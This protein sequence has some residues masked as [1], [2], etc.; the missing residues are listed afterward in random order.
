M[1]F[2]QSQVHTD[3]TTRLLANVDALSGVFSFL[4]VNTAACFACEDFFSAWYHITGTLDT[5]R[6]YDRF[7][8]MFRVWYDSEMKWFYKKKFPTIERGK[9]CDLLFNKFLTSHALANALRSTLRYI[10]VQ[11]Q[12]GET[13]RREFRYDVAQKHYM[14]GFIGRLQKY[15]PAVLQD[16]DE[17]YSPRAEYAHS[18]HAYTLSFLACWYLPYERLSWTTTFEDPE[19]ISIS[20]TPYELRNRFWHEIHSREEGDPVWDH[21]WNAMKLGPPSLQ[22]FKFALRTF[23]DVFAKKKEFPPLV[24][25]FV[26]QTMASVK[27]AR[28]VLTYYK[29]R[30]GICCSFPPNLKGVSSVTRE[31]FL[32]D[33]LPVLDKCLCGKKQLAKKGAKWVKQYQLWFPASWE[34]VS[35]EAGLKNILNV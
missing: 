21:V 15:L 13:F 31:A 2:V 3:A 11:R 19:D 12:I 26:Q 35:R 29:R 18:S 30:H 14:C 17:S 34:K 25:N 1:P 9:T 20:R 27:S 10:S 16:F 32:V 28:M 4:V 5:L 23:P 7:Q 8:E 22:F 24:E 33:A 6:T